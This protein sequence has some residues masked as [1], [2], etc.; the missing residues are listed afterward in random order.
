[1]AITLLVKT[2]IIDN[3][4]DTAATIQTWAQN[5]TV[6]TVHGFTC[7]PINSQQSRLV[8]IYT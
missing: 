3:I 1:M 5:T 4:G 6:T 7:V 8:L 2:L